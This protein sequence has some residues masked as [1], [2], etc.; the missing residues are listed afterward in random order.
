MSRNLYEISIDLDAILN[1]IE[2]NEGEITEELEEALTITQA[3]FDAKANDYV[4]AV[5]NI[6][7]DINATKC[8][9]TRLSNRKKILENQVTKLKSVLLDAVNKFGYIGK[10]NN[11]IYN[12]DIAKLFTRNTQSVDIDEIRAQLFCTCIREYIK[13]VHN[14]DSIVLSEALVSINEINKTICD[15]IPDCEYI[16]FTIEDLHTIKIKISK[17]YTA[18][19][20]ILS[21]YFI[22]KDIV[23]EV[24]IPSQYEFE[25]VNSKS[26]LKYPLTAGLKLS[27]AKLNDNTSLTIK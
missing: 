27:F 11:K 3:E 7:S 18:E 8:E 23:N 20:L 21:N 10:S 12:T 2:I 5:R 24:V 13:S 14:T 15:T 25:C 22:N 4:K 1:E 26:E 16:P 19:S 6:E 9:A 17:E